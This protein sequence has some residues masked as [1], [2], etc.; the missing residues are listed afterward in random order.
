MVGF[1]SVC[2][3]D[4]IGFIISLVIGMDIYRILVLLCVLFAVFVF[5]AL[6]LFVIEVKLFF[7]LLCYFRLVVTCV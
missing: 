2:L 5:V 7:S 3:V 1:P 4:F 6:G